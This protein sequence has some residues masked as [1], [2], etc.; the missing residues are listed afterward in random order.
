MH[1][2]LKTRYLEDTWSH[3]EAFGVINNTYFLFLLSSSVVERRSSF[4]RNGCISFRNLFISV[5]IICKRVKHMQ[6]YW[7]YGRISTIIKHIYLSAGCKKNKHISII[8]K[9]AVW[10][11]T[12]LR[13]VII[14]ITLNETTETTKSKGYY[15][16]Q[17]NK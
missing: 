4:I 16:K 9:P 10:K 11:F 2:Q 7:M 1:E 15:S 6:T 14:I 8:I 13:N 17:R 5:Q 12:K 3:F